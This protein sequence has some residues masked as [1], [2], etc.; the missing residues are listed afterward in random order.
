MGVCTQAGG[1]ALPVGHVGAQHLGSTLG[2]A[3][4]FGGQHLDA[5]GQ[6]H[7]GFALHLHAVLQ[8]FDGFDA[9]GQ[10]LLEAGQ[11]LARQWRT[12]LGGIT[13]PGQGVGHVQARQG[14]QSIGLVGPFHGHGFLGLG[15]A[16]LFE[17]FAQRLG[18]ALVAVREFLEHLGHALGR[19]IGGEPLAHPCGAVARGG[20][21]EH[22]ACQRIQRLGVCSFGGRGVR[23][24]GVHSRNGHKAC[25]VGQTRIVAAVGAGFTEYRFKATKA[26]GRPGRRG[27]AHRLFQAPQTRAHPPAHRPPG[28]P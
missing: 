5:L 4:G 28:V 10:C 8:V 2:V 19:G 14:E 1:L 24:S 26:A 18:R 22:P 12:G 7:G 9:F 21:R 25:L 11:R 23:L 17:F 16:Q 20:G 6:Q 13:L 15:A 27:P 3:P